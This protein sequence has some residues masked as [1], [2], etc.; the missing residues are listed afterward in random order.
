MCTYLMVLRYF[1]A[2][3]QL[4]LYLNIASLIWE[5]YGSE[6]GEPKAE[7][8]G[9]SRQTVLVKWANSLADSATD[10]CLWCG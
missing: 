10:D 6:E 8:T 9:R 5:G 2:V 4:F 7:F 3:T 1:C